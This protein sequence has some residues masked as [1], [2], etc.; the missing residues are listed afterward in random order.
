MYCARYAYQSIPRFSVYI[1][2]LVD[3]MGKS[4]CWEFWVGVLYG[5]GKGIPAWVSYIVFIT[6]LQCDFFNVVVIVFVTT[7]TS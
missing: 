6:L 4:T 7:L 1:Y 2:I 5:I 3:E